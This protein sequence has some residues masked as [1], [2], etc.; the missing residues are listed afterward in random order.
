M[1]DGGNCP[2]EARVS[3][4]KSDVDMLVAA[5]VKVG[6]RTCIGGGTETK[7]EEAHE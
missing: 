7:H 4:P 5:V 1:G 6:L 2:V 3:K